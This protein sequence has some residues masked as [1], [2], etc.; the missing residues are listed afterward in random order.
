MSPQFPGM[1]PYLENPELWSEVHFGLISVLARSLNAIITPKYRAA[2]EKRV[3]SDTLLVGIPDV[4]VFQRNSKMTE[5][6]QS[7][8]TLSEPFG[9]ETQERFLEIREVGTGTVVTVVEALSPKNKRAGEGKVKYNAKRQAVLNSTAHLVEIDLLRTGEP[10]LVAG[11]IASDYRILVSRANCRP[12]AD[13]Y[14]FNLRESLPCFLLPLRLGDREPV[15]D[16]PAVLKQTYEEAALD[17]AIDYTQPPIPPVS[18]DDF[19]WIQSLDLA[20]ESP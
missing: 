4:T 15:I 19:A 17:L 16:L 9:E 12:A 8:V 10:M 1:N 6:Q 18:D 5:P 14:P 2:V 13:L 3:Y 7:V 20:K 11:G